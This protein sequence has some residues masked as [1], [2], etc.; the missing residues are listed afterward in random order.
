MTFETF[1]KE[2][3]DHILNYLPE[4]YAKNNVRIEETIKKNGVKWT[5]LIIHGEK[6]ITPNIYLESFYNQMAEGKELSSV[7]KMIAEVYQK[8]QNPIPKFD[9]ESVSRENIIDKLY[10]AAVNAELDSDMLRDAVKE[11]NNMQMSEE[12]ILSESAYYHEADTQKV[13]Q[14]EENSQSMGME[15]EM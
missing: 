1:C 8:S 3:K 14:V 11:G 7:M 12:G 9:R 2:V 4:E 6:N 15:M 13:S 10:V 5:G